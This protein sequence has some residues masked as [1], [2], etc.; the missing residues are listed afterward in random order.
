[1]YVEIEGKPCCLELVVKIDDTFVPQGYSKEEILSSV[2]IHKEK[3]V[4]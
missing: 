3:Y 2:R 1:M 4:S